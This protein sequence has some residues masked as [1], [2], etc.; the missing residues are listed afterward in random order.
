MALRSWKDLVFLISSLVF[1]LL[2]HRTFADSNDYPAGADKLKIGAKPVTGVMTSSNQNDY[3]KF[4]V[5]TSVKYIIDLRHSSNDRNIDMWLYRGCDNAQ[6]TDHCEVSDVIEVGSR[7]WGDNEQ[8][9]FVAGFSGTVHLQVFANA[10]DRDTPYSLRV[11]VDDNDFPRDA[12]SLKLGDKPITG[13]ASW[14]DNEYYKFKVKKSRKYIIDMRYHHLF[15]T[16]EDADLSMILY[17]GCEEAD[18]EECGDV[19]QFIESSQRSGDNNEQIGFIAE[20]SETVWLHIWGAYDMGD[21]SIPY[22]IRAF[23]AKNDSPRSAIQLDVGVSSDFQ[24]DDDLPVPTPDAI[25]GSIMSA[26]DND[27]Y[28]FEAV[29]DNTYIIDLIYEGGAGWYLEMQ[30]ENNCGK[31]A[32]D[33]LKWAHAR[34]QFYEQI[35]YK[36][37]KTETV[38]V[39][40]FSFG[41]IP[42]DPDNAGDYTIHVRW[43]NNERNIAAPIYVGWAPVTA[44]VNEEHDELWYTFS[45]QQGTTYIIKANFPNPPSTAL[46]IALKDSSTTSEVGSCTAKTSTLTQCRYTATTTEQMWI[47]IHCGGAPYYPCAELLTLQL[48]ACSQAPDDNDDP[49]QAEAIV[50]NGKSHS[51]EASEKDED[52]FSFSAKQGTSYTITLKLN[53][54]SEGDLDLGLYQGC[55]SEECDDELAISGED[56]GEEVIEWDAAET[57]TLW[58]K[59]YSVNDPCPIKYKI[60]IEGQDPPCSYQCPD[61]SV[62][63]KDCVEKFKQCECQGGYK[64]NNEEETCEACDFET[65]PLYSVRK[66]Q[67]VTNAGKHCKCLPSTKMECTAAGDCECKPCDTFQCGDFASIK[68]GVQCVTKFKHCECEPGYKKKDGECVPK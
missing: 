47:Y 51:G 37:T 4:K 23:E 3:Y 54:G 35:E 59:V 64:A 49:T 9:T 25:P 33:L 11:S 18:G 67:C 46:E 27:W 26:F 58:V 20:N 32:C 41:G 12:D 45:A 31:N 50:V 63:K 66:T 43:G 30:L 38:W 65:C 5:K 28:K 1:G 19:G 61:F 57:E 40:V 10:Y 39:K 16:P 68:E 6:G 44:T 21:D 13:L 7:D 36:A 48:S 56:G 24:L 55:S 2:L 14:D 15:P 42:S 17:R 60:K 8:I 22:T 62:P 53:K 29:K 52:W 34:T